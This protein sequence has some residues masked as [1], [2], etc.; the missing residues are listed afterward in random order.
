MQVELDGKF[1]QNFQIILEHIAKD[2]ITASKNFKKELLKQIKNLP[3]FPYKY[4][5]SFYF[6]DE[7]IRDMTFKSY[8][9]VYEV[10]IDENLI[11]VLNIFN[12]NK[13]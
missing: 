10:N 6:K 8:T 7:N 12:Q 3:N 2:K 9:I 11:V 1:K 4:R 13:R 5:K